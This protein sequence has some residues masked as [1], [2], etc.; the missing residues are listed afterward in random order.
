ML[1][2]LL[3]N[4]RADRPLPRDD[5]GVVERMHERHLLFLCHRA[6]LCVRFVEGVAGEFYRGV[7]AAERAD[8]F[9]FLSR[10]VARHENGSVDF[11]LGAAEGDTLRVIPCRGAHDA[12]FFLRSREEPHAVVRAA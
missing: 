10:R 1:R 8:A 6:G 3:Q 5:Y 4:F 12:A 2:V 9:Y 11:E 7:R